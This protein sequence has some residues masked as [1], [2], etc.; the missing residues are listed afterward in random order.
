[1]ASNAKQLRILVV[2]DHKDTVDLTALLLSNRG[3]SV[4]RAY[5]VEE[6]KTAA[7]AIRCDVLM[8]DGSLPDGNGVELL[9]EFKAKYGMAGIM[10]SGTIEDG[11]TIEAEGFTFLPKP[12]HFQKLLGLLES[13]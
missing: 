8:T 1:M 9:R 7:S 13:L 5:S 4:A 3:Y 10:V 2:D 12:L 6:A 11:S